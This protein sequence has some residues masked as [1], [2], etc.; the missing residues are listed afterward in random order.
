ML[1]PLQPPRHRVLAERKDLAV[2]NGTQL[3]TEMK[4]KHDRDRL[5]D[6]MGMFHQFGETMISTD[7]LQEAIECGDFED[8]GFAR[9]REEAQK[10]GQAMVEHGLVFDRNWS[11]DV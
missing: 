4:M 2:S 3:P 8:N 10:L 9:N 11:D 6:I 1:P 5:Q 7:S